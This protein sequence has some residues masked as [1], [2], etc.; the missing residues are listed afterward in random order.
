M[1]PRVSALEREEFNAALNGIEFVQQPV[2]ENAADAN[3]YMDEEG[4]RIAA[5]LQAEAER[6]MERDALDP[7]K[8]SYFMRMDRRT[9]VKD[10]REYHECVAKQIPLKVIPYPHAVQAVKEEEARKRQALKDK[11]KKKAAKQARKKNRR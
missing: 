7:T 3:A 1:M 9:V 4:Q 8:Q 5:E 6:V 2:F 10:E 11:R